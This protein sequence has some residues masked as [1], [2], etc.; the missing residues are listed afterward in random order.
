MALLVTM[1]TVLGK[2]KPIY[3][4]VNTLTL[5]NHGVEAPALLRGFASEEDYRAGAPFV[6]ERELD[7][8]PLDVSEPLWG[9]VYANLKALPL[10]EN[11]E[12]C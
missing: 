7:V 10:F 8:S 1:D 4:R 2:D 9:Q 3:V 5:S 11:A 6:Y 12:D